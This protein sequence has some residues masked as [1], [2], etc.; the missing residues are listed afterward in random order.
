MRQKE[1]GVLR[2]RDGVYQRS[3]RTIVEEVERFQNVDDDVE[4][5]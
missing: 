4:H 5:D 1:E 3:E 2:L